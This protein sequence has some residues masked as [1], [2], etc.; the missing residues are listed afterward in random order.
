MRN[1][2]LP[3]AIVVVILIAVA[4]FLQRERSLVSYGIP[5][6]G[7][8]IMI[9]KDFS[10]LTS[11]IIQLPGD[12]AVNSIGLSTTRLES[13]GCTATSAPLGYL[14]YDMDK[15]GKKAGNVNGGSIYYV[16]PD[17][18]CSAD[19]SLQDWRKLESSLQIKEGTSS[20]Q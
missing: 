16:E 11:V 12:Q 1:I 3:L 17:K 2:A 8:I 20:S 6:L 9:P 10:D 7:T 18:P 13:A 4:Y 5:E 14:T 19:T 15:G